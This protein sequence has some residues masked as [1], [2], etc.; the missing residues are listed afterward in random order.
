MKLFVSYAHKDKDLV[1][2][3]LPVLQ[4]GGIEF[5]RDVE[6]LRIG[7]NWQDELRNAIRESD[8]IILA[9]TPNW[10]NSSYCQWEFVTAYELGKNVYPVLLTKTD[11]PQRLSQ[12][13]YYDFTQGFNDQDGNQRFIDELLKQQVQRIQPASVEDIDKAKQ[14]E[15]INNSISTGDVSGSVLT[16]GGITTGDITVNGRGTANVVIGGIINQIANNRWL[17]LLILIVLLV[18]IFILIFVVLPDEQL[19][20]LQYSVGMIPASATPTLTPTATLTPS[21]TPTPT[22]TP[23]IAD[24]DVGI[25]VTYFSIPDDG[26]VESVEADT[27]IQ[28][29]YSRLEAELREFGGEVDLSIGL[30]PPS[31]VGRIEGETISDREESAE[32]IA[33]RYG[34][35]MV[36]YGTISERADNRLEVQPEFY[37]APEKFAEALELTGSYRLGRQIEVEGPL[38]LIRNAM[39]VNRPL[40]SRTTAAAQIFAGL[41]YYLL[42][43]YESALEAFRAAEAVP[44]WDNTEGKEV[45]YVLLGNAQGKLASVAAQKG[46]FERAAELV[47]P[48]IEQYE[49]AIELAPDYSRPYTGIASTLYLKWNANTQATGESDINMLQEVLVQ[50]DMAQEALDR[51]DDISIETKELFTRAQADFWLWYYHR[52]EFDDGGERVYEDFQRTTEQIIRRY[53]QGRNPS[54][55]ELASESYALIGTM[56]RMRDDCE[57]AVDEYQAAID[58]SVSTL[59]QMFF[60]GWL[61]DCYV[62]LNQRD[63]AAQSYEQALE[64]ANDLDDVPEERREDYQMKL[65]ELRGRG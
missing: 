37:V 28:Q 15:V 5:W 60:Y 1:D 53:D 33:E 36:L 51:P 40:S 34:A 59:R 30:L 2:R 9:L 64:Y 32:E 39:N 43:D 12:Y 11:L 26:S 63:L 47:E 45:V 42:E 19:A 49:Q 21:P 6:Q 29:V 65:T 44:E 35:D 23:T 46:D 41:T 3:L 24:Y 16:S 52:D 54:V 25:A 20:S 38:T 8:G 48:T 17:I 4:G 55:Q 10:T 27:L 57:G 62:M 22:S 18:V 13:Q 50:L 31:V 14:A 56:S 61:G 7:Q 58:L